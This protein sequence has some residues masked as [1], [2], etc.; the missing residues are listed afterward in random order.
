MLDPTAPLLPRFGLATQIS[1]CAQNY[2][3]EP[4]SHPTLLPGIFSFPY[5]EGKIAHQFALFEHTVSTENKNGEKLMWVYNLN[6]EYTSMLI[7]LYNLQ[8]DSIM[9]YSLG[10]R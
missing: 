6:L 5:V 3:L 2:R 8:T 9:P 7:I 10:T 1:M 4:Q